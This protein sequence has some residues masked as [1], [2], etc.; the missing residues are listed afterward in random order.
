MNRQNKRDFEHSIQ[1]QIK[2]KFGRQTEENE[3][4]ICE[5]VAKEIQWIYTTTGQQYFYE[6]NLSAKSIAKNYEPKFKKPGSTKSTK[7]FSPD[8]SQRTQNSP[9]INNPSLSSIWSQPFQLSLLINCGTE[10]T[11]GLI[12]VLG[13]TIKYDYTTYSTIGIYETNTKTHIISEFINNP[14]SKMFVIN[15]AVKD[16][17]NKLLNDTG[18]LNKEI[19]APVLEK[20]IDSQLNDKFNKSFFE[21]NGFTKFIELIEETTICVHLKSL[22]PSQTKSVYKTLG[23]KQVPQSNLNFLWSAFSSEF[24]DEIF[25]SKLKTYAGKK[26]EDILKRLLNAEINRNEPFYVADNNSFY[27]EI[28]NNLEDNYEQQDLFFMC[29]LPLYFY[30]IEHKK[31]IFDYK[32]T[33]LNDKKLYRIL[34]GFSKGDGDNLD[35][36]YKSIDSISSF[37][38]IERKEII[39]EWRT[40]IFDLHQIWAYLTDF[41]MESNTSIKFK[42][43]NGPDGNIAKQIKNINTIQTLNKSNIQKIYKLNHDNT[44]PITNLILNLYSYIKRT[45]NMSVVHAKTI[46]ELIPKHYNLSYV[47]F[48]NNPHNTDNILENKLI[49]TWK[50]ENNGKSLPSTLELLN[51]IEGKSI[52]SDGIIHIHNEFFNEV[53]INEI[54]KDPIFKSHAAGEKVKAEFLKILENNKIDYETNPIML[55]TYGVV[56]NCGNPNDSEYINIGHFKER[57][58]GGLVYVYD[59]SESNIVQFKF[60]CE[61][62]DVNQQKEKNVEKDHNKWWEKQIRYTN[63]KCEELLAL[64]FNLDNAFGLKMMLNDTNKYYTHNI[65]SYNGVERYWKEYKNAHYLKENLKKIVE[66]IKDVNWVESTDYE[67]IEYITNK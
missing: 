32:T 22:T 35:H 57:K 9:K 66:S 45:R 59:D 65:D 31:F 46:I 7:L 18:L 53:L 27:P 1:E 11:D 55:T 17:A 29:Y 41:E 56:V 58:D 48:L 38:G 24:M 16:E 50:E 21:K 36:I 42:N 40:I 6:I 51:T 64:A 19:I 13:N 54:E 23:T 39:D 28:H 33:L 63:Y 60:L 26:E 15:K 34:W 47:K 25:V 2:K 10:T 12:R 8:D 14:D 52:G 49:H 43:I 44:C 61:R 30:N 3:V 37:S 5:F 20:I 4:K 67:S 62:R